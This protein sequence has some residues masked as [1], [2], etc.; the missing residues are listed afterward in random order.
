MI[1]L[2]VKIHWM[3]FVETKIKIGNNSCNFLK[4]IKKCESGKIQMKTRFFHDAERFKKF[5]SHIN[6]FYTIL[7]GGEF[8]HGGLHIIK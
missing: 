8:G 1:F 4:F 2:C 3:F 6:F 5:S 7:R